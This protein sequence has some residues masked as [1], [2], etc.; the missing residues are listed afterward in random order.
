ALREWRPTR[1][2][3]RL[4]GFTSNRVVAVRLAHLAGEVAVGLGVVDELLALR[5]P[6]ELAAQ[7]H[8]DD[9]Q[10]T[11]RHRAVAD[12]GLGDRRLAAA[13]APEEVAHVVAALA[14]LDLRRLQPR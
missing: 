9:A 11:H 2:A 8:G 3:S 6:A 1:G 4:R 12:L 7:P 14:Q 10:V 5:V 13:D